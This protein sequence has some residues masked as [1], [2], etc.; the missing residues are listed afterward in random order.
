[1]VATRMDCR[2]AARIDPSD[3]VQ[4]TFTQAWQKL[5]VYL[6]ERPVP[7]YVWL[8]DIAWQRLQ[9]HHEQHIGAQ[10]RTVNR[11]Q[12][13]PWSLSDQ[14]HALLAGQFAASQ[15]SPSRHVSAG[16]QRDRVRAALDQLAPHHREVIILRHL[17]QLSFEEMAA[18]LSITQESTYS[19]YRRAVVRLHELLSDSSG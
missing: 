17:E 10:K 14:S 12:D 6:E 16:E 9:H 2:L 1:M 13:P 11:E 15:T 5:P 4:E 3:I 19:R 18:T 8:R 7:F